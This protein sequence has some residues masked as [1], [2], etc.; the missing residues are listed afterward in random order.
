MTSSSEVPMKHSSEILEDIGYSRTGVQVRS[1][2]TRSSDGSRGGR[3]LQKRLDHLWARM[4]AIFGDAWLSR[5]GSEDSGLWASVLHRLA[6]DEIKRG[7]ELC[8][9]DWEGGWPPTP[10]K[11]IAMARIPSA[12]RA[13]DRSRLLAVKPAQ[14]HVRD[15]HLRKMRELL[16]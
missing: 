5:Y 3:D 4:I 8:V 11:F 1:E 2:A 12:H 14:D 7:V 15:E 6:D 16:R 13:V 9:T 10:G